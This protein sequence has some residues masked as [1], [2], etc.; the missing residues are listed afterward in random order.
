MSSRFD[1]LH[2]TQMGANM[3]LEMRDHDDMCAKQIRGGYLTISVVGEGG[4]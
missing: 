1:E 3:C 2:P 4:G